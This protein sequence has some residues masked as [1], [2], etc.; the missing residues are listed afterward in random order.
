[1]ENVDIY[2]CSREGKKFQ[3]E[4]LRSSQNLLD[5]GCKKL[6]VQLAGLVKSLPNNKF[7]DWSNLKAFAYD[8]INMTQK[9]KFVLGWVE[10]I[11]GKGENA[12]Y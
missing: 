6:A 12:G 10:N 9:L 8:K 5:T 3:S 7:L 2:V 4:F 11:V 1:M